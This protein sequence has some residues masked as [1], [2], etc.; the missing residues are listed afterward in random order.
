MLLKVT[1]IVELPDANDFEEGEELVSNAKTNIERT[2]TRME[3]SGITLESVEFTEDVGD[4][5]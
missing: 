5:F 2:L 1:A 4:A 3:Y